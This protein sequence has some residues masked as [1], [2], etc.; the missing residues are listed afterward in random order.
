MWQCCSKVELG[1]QQWCPGPLQENDTIKVGEGSFSSS[2]DDRCVTLWRKKER[3]SAITSTWTAGDSHLRGD[4]HSAAVEASEQ[5]R[6][7]QLCLKQW[8][9][10]SKKAT[11]K[12]RKK[13]KKSM[14]WK[15]DGKEMKLI[16]LYSTCRSG[17]EGTDLHHWTHWQLTALGVRRLVWGKGVMWGEGGIPQ[18]RLAETDLCVHPAVFLN[19]VSQLSY[20][21]LYYSVS[22]LFHAF[23]SSNA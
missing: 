7:L 22:Q 3:D 21:S 11:K 15:D 1:R 18:L 12:K 8:G 17:A 10:H 5:Q 20:Q 9:A 19:S 6:R 13:K 14:H 16:W 4:P 23:V 2:P